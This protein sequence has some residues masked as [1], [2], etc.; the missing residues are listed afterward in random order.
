MECAG[1]GEFK[2]LRLDGEQPAIATE[3][4]HVINPA[5]EL[6]ELWA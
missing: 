4:I 5:T 2:V 3:N 1:C 6:Q